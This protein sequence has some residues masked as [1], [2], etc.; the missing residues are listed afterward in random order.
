[1][2]QSN[3]QYRTIGLLVNDIA[4]DFSRG[5][6]RGVADSLAG[7][8]D[9]YLIVLAGLYDDGGSRS[10][11]FHR[12]KVIYNSIY[13]V[14][15]LC[16]LDSLIFSLD[17]VG[18]H[19]TW[20]L[21]QSYIRRFSSIPKVLIAA[22]DQEGC[23]TVN[24]DN[25]T[26][27]REAVDCMVNVHGLTR[28][29][30]L[31][32]RD[33][34]RD[35]QLRRNVFV[36]CLANYGITLSE[37]QYERSDMSNN[38]EAA[39][40]RLLD[41][42]PDAQA[43]FCV[44]DATAAG[45]YAAMEKRDLVPGRDI[46][47]LG[48]DNTHMAE[49]MLPPLT[50]VGTDTVNLGQKAFELALTMMYG[51]EAHSEVVKTRL[52]GRE[53]LKYETYVYSRKELLDVNPDYIYRMF[54]D[55]F[56]RYN[57]DNISREQV[58]LKRLFYEIISNML[59]ALRR[60]SIDDEK[61]SEIDRMLT[62]FFANGAMLY[63]DAIKLLKIIDMF[64]NTINSAV[65]QC[66][67]LVR[68]NRLLS[69]MKDLA[70][71]TISEYRIRERNANALK[72]ELMHDFV[73]STM[74]F[75]PSPSDSITSII[76]NIQKLGLRSASLC[77]FEKPVICDED[78]EAAALPEQINLCCTI[79]N[80]EP[81]IIPEGRRRRFIKDL[82]TVHEL[83]ARGAAHALFPIFYGRSLYG[84]LI[85]ELTDV[86]YD[87]GEYISSQIG[88]AIYINELTRS[89]REQAPDE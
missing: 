4:S 58:N 46:M 89:R 77:L 75:S 35:A 59:Y 33:D 73:V 60:R 19:S 83:F 64:Q 78:D 2:E 62:V 27:V 50:S 67:A 12:Y 40:G 11:K 54:D 55:C 29:C 48:F 30:M 6:I 63:T 76:T 8:K 7:H 69:R 87:N 18:I 26:G 41:R 82:F 57:S 36:K 52:Y 43:V 5:V 86:I 1:M 53:S 72:L 65:E 74:D 88:M 39:A 81:Y 45:L 28:L 56:Y 34:N 80:G 84:L 42:N 25:E 20:K 61:F 22:D 38:S 49:E 17:R 9:I 10:D 47:V 14:A 32:G 68:I 85:C 13:K 15:E 51:G 70:A 21:G 31:G 16:E 23:V 71:T 44:N 79:K 66:D 37:D 24:F 3:K